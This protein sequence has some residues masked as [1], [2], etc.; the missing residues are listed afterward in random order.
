ASHNKRGNGQAGKPSVDCLEQFVHRRI[1][2]SAFS[3]CICV[4][5]DLSCV[6]ANAAPPLLAAGVCLQTLHRSEK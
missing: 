2:I 1:I 4:P 6:A 3:F 5:P